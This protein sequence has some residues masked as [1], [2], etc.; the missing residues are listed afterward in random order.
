MFALRNVVRLSLLAVL[1]IALLSIPAA[2]A[3][4]ADDALPSMACDAAGQAADGTSGSCIPR[5]EW[6]GLADA[7]AEENITSDSD[8]IPMKE[9]SRDRIIAVVCVF[10]F[11]L[12]YICCMIYFAFSGSLP[13]RM[14]LWGIVP[15]AFAAISVSSVKALLRLKKHP[16]PVVVLRSC[17]SDKNAAELAE[18]IREYAVKADLQ[19][20]ELQQNLQLTHVGLQAIVG[21]ILGLGCKGPLV[22]LDLSQNPQLG[23]P[24]IDGL[25]PLLQKKLS[26]ITCLKVGWCSLT[27]DGV[28]RLAQQATK[29][30]LTQLD[31]SCNDLAG[32]GSILAELLEAPLI[33]DLNLSSCDLGDEDVVALAQQLPYTVL[34]SLQ[35][36]S[37]RVGDAGLAALAAALPDTQLQELGLEGNFIDV[38]PGLSALGMAWAKR[39]FSRLSLQGNKL[40]DDAMKEFYQTLRSLR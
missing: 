1:L 12:A 18:T 27:K 10:G 33:D 23:D 17:V 19:A 3:E 28:Q 13:A 29:S 30:K 5:D 35:L 26:A 32:A 25:A 16:T 22:E 14:A 37:N 6:T 8:H 20:L 36:G 21:A 4:A 15:E 34:K 24:A 39:P 40:S 38:G 2:V 9:W 7:A 11:I 31:L